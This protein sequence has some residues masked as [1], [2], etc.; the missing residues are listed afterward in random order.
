MTTK[1]KIQ[2]RAYLKSTGI[3]WYNID[4]DN[5]HL[6]ANTPAF[7]VYKMNAEAK[8]IGKPFMDL[9]KVK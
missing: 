2:L 5:I 8:E 9:M 6:Y 3:S 1:E 4:P 7:S